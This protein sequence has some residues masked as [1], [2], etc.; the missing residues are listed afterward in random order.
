M[1]LDVMEEWP[2][3]RFIDLRDNVDNKLMGV[4]ED[5]QHF[6]TFTQH[7][8]PFWTVSSLRQK[9]TQLKASV[10]KSRTLEDSLKKMSIRPQSSP[11]IRQDH[12]QPKKVHQKPPLIIQRSTTIHDKYRKEKKHMKRPSTCLTN[13][14]HHLSSS[15]SSISCSPDE[16]TAW[17]DNDSNSK[18]NMLPFEMYG[19]DQTS[20][21]NDGCASEEFAWKQTM[22]KKPHKNPNF[23]RVQDKEELDRFCENFEPRFRPRERSKS[24][25]RNLKHH[26]LDSCRNYDEKGGVY[27]EFQRKDAHKSRMQALPSKKLTSS[28]VGNQTTSFL[29]EITQAILH[30]KGT[31]ESIP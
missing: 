16:F 6:T 17:D 4:L 10:K 31:I 7:H 5:K 28:I 11:I 22:Q 9:R 1:L 23:N 13:D 12:V 29:K 21:M 30:L 15:S 18:E 26:E 2:V 3:L 19:A 8:P 14:R 25:S 27:E 20:D 24:G